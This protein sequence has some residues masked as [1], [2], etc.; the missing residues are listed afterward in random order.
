MVDL[1]KI[2]F[3]SL[4]GDCRPTYNASRQTG[5]CAPLFFDWLV[6]P[7]RAIIPLIE[8]HFSAA[9]DADMTTW[10]DR[11]HE[12]HVT[13]HRYGLVSW[14]QFKSR[15]AAHVDT[16]T[17]GIRWTGRAF[18]DLLDDPEPAI[19]VR[20]WSTLDGADRDGAAQ[21]LF[22]YLCA[23]KPNSVMLYLN[24]HEDI[25][26]RID[27][28]FIVSEPEPILTNPWWGDEAFYDRNLTLASRVAADI[29]ATAPT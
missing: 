21:D 1:S 24:P 8:T 12:F 6:T 18:L 14:H 29:F 16:M 3:I 13:D 11:P 2:R 28:R 7:L 19:F 4:G 27:G 15:D 25:R 26:A 10:E 23:R 5:P 17:K 9:F 20:R 22:D